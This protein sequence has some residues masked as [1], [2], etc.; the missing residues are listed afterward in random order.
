M[1][2]LTVCGATRTETGSEQVQRFV[3]L[4][5]FV[6]LLTGRTWLDV[7]YWKEIVLLRLL[8]VGWGFLVSVEVCPYQAF[9]EDAESPGPTV[10]DL[11]NFLSNQLFRFGR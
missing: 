4:F 10:V 7:L 2:W 6:G 3:E 8:A 11:V 1:L 5:A 9:E